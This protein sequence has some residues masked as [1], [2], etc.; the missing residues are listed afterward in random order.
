MRLGHFKVGATFAISFQ[1]RTIVFVRRQ[2]I[3]CD[4]SPCHIVGPF[5]RQ[6]VANKMAATS[7]N[8]GAPIFGLCFESVALERVDFIPD[9]ASNGH[10]ES[11]FSIGKLNDT[12]L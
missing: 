3:K 10:M 5:V 6:E 11:P 2:A 4:Q 12:R 8:D 7:R 9:E 1:S